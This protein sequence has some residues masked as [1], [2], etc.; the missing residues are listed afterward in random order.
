MMDDFR[1][2]LRQVYLSLEHTHDIDSNSEKFGVAV[3]LMETFMRLTRQDKY[4]WDVRDLS[5]FI[6][7]PDVT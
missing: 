5:S 6:S 2:R 4:I 3:M 7:M 1:G